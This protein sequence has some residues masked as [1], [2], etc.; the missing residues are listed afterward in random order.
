MSKQYFE[1]ELEI[2]KFSEDIV[3]ASS[4]FGPGQF[5]NTADDVYNFAE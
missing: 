2:V 1:V 4:D 3:T 5:D